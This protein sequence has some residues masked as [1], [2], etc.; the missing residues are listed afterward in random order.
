MKP[1]KFR[2]GGRRLAVVSAFSLL[3][4]FVVLFRPSTLANNN[5]KLVASTDNISEQSSIEVATEFNQRVDQTDGTGNSENSE[6]VT[7]TLS[8]TQEASE[9]SLL[10]QTT[11]ND[12]SYIDEETVDHRNPTKETANKAKSAR[13]YNNDYDYETDPT[14]SSPS[15]SSSSSPPSRTTTKNTAAVLTKTSKKEKQLQKQHPL[16]KMSIPRL[17]KQLA[18][19]YTR[20]NVII[21]TWANLHF[22]DFVLNWVAHVQRHGITNFL[23]GAMDEE[24]AEFLYQSGLTENIF[25]MYVDNATD[26]GLTTADFGWGSATF[27]K[28]GRQKVD[29]AATFTSFGLDL[30]LCDVDTVW[31]N[32]KFLC[33]FFSAPLLHV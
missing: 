16:N 29:L 24:T 1:R 28:M 8:T 12:D 7:A 14:P 15:S 19:R 10:A 26:T 17:S 5:I 23:V 33:F 22:S 18:H 30:C 6:D 32:G 27:H 9:T 20:N 11:Q 3:A 4:A 31:I 13:L 2:P 21:V 25:A